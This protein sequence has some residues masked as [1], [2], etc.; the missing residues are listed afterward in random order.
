MEG[1]VRGG[2]A[3]VLERKLP[4]NAGPQIYSVGVLSLLQWLPLVAQRE[5]FWR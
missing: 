5:P 2:I 4:T 1:F 3:Q